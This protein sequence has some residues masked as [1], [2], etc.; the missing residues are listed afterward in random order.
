MNICAKFQL[1]SWSRSGWKVCVGG[2]GVGGGWGGLHSHFH[3][4]PNRC[5]M[6]CWGWGFDKNVIIYASFFRKRSCFQKFTYWKGLA[7][8]CNMFSPAFS[9]IVLFRFFPLF[10]LYCVLFTLFWILFILYCY[11]VMQGMLSLPTAN[12]RKQKQRFGYL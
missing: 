8:Q 9:S 1:S 12:T 10:K 5:V 7:V 2:G 6:L 4:Q 3:S 11:A